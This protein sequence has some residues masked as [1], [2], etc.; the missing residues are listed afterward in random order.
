M[1]TSFFLKLRKDLLKYLVGQTS[2]IYLETKSKQ[3]SW[4]YNTYSLHTF[5]SGSLGKE[6]AD[7]LN[8]NQLELIP[9]AE[10]HDIFHVITGFGIESEEEVAMQFWLLGNGRFKPFTIGACIIGIILLP[11]YWKQYMRSFRQGMNAPLIVNWDFEQMLYADL[12][13]IKCFVLQSPPLLI[14]PSLV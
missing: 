10:S 2:E 13:Q 14:K 12:N 9:K 5:P 8:E 3:L 11:D 7:F 1:T 6:L 4:D